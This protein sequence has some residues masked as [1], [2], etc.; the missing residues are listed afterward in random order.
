[1][2]IYRT[3]ATYRFGNAEY[4]RSARKQ[5]RLELPDYEI[6]ITRKRFAATHLFLSLSLSPYECST[7]IVRLTNT[8]FNVNGFTIYL[9]LVNH[10]LSQR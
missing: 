10:K 8:A 3:T 7:R 9:F 5:L 2:Q 6:E 1:M 4:K